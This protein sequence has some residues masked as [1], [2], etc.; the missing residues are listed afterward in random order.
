MSTSKTRKL[1]AILF[2]DIVGYTALMQKDEAT[3]NQNLEKFHQTLNEKV[4]HHKGHIINNYGDG[5]VCT[6]DSAVDAMHCAKEVQHIFQSEPKV[7]VRIGLHSGDVFFKDANVYGDSVNIASRIESLGVAGAVLFS[8]RIKRHIAN[9]T[10]FK[11]QSLGA[12]HFKNVEKTMEVFGLVNERLILPKK[13]ELQGKLKNKKAKRA[14][15]TVWMATILGV[16]LIVGGFFV[17][18]MVG[19]TFKVSPTISPPSIAV[20]PFED[21]SPNKDQ[22]YFGD[23]IAEEILNT[24]AQLQALKV[25]GRTSSFSFK[26][27]EAT[28]AEIGKTLKVN[29]ILEGSVR[30]QG[31]KIRITAQLIKVADGFHIWSEKYDRDF[32][33]IFAI[34]DELA[35]SIGEVL[36]EKLAPEQVVKLA[37]NNPQ[38]SEAYE[39]FL[40]AKYIYQ[41]R[42][43]TS[44]NIKDFNYCEDLFLKAIAL[45]STYALAHAG[46]ADLYD[47]SGNFN[48][49]S[50]QGNYYRALKLKESEIAIQLDSNNAYIH[51]VRGWCLRGQKKD[52]RDDKSAFRHF[53]KSY[54]L[55]PN[56]WYGLFGLAWSYRYKSLLTDAYQ[57]LD[58]AIELNPTVPLVYFGK[59]QLLTNIHDDFESAIKLNKTVLDLAPHHVGALGVLGDCYFLLNK[60]AAALAAYQK[61]EGID[62]SFME[63]NRTQRIRLALLKGD[64][65]KA[66]S[67]NPKSWSY[68]YFIGDHA[69]LEKAVLKRFKALTFGEEQESA[70]QYLTKSVYT[71][72]FRQKPAFQELLK[73][74]KDK[75]DQ[76]YK[77]YPRASEILIKP[78][79][80]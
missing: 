75:Y 50:P 59:A 31:D 16:L 80:D 26:D 12:F 62:S 10:D 76:F 39:L 67:L 27:K 3:A 1:A 35:Q 9:Q 52:K 2:A 77:E 11:V 79:K 6:F 51:G 61:I 33:D 54:Q 72:H 8:K 22:A 64:T 32:D 24:L 56:D 17:W 74:E 28:I 30:K 4:N 53:L 55:A 36:L 19:N 60:K 42:Y 23:G 46:L 63:N 48:W 45:D 44:G 78:L 47:T 34:Q 38:N 70:Y 58:R 73:K 66:K 5:C 29:H 49:D 7:P 57:F 20:L 68:L 13:E 65:T 21:M 25:A 40:K 15:K 37:S 14:N 41:H 71:K 43:S 69:A 18:N